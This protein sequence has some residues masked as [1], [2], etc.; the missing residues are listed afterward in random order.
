MRSVYSSSA[1]KNENEVIKSIR[2]IVSD[3]KPVASHTTRSKA[4]G[5]NPSRRPIFTKK[6]VF[7]SSLAREPL[8]PR[9]SERSSLLAAAFKS[10]ARS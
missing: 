4:P 7:P 9:L 10:P 5:F 2:P 6:R 8:S 3:F 1:S